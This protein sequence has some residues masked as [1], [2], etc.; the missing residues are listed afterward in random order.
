MTPPAQPS[1]RRSSAS[2]A[3]VPCQLDNEIWLDVEYLGDASSPQASFVND[4]T[5]DL[6]ATAANQSFQLGDMGRLD[7]QVQA[8]GEFHAAAKGLDLC[9]GQVREGIQHVLYRSACH[10]DLAS[11]GDYQ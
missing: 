6:L 11:R 7:H 9:A 4:G 3:A 5:A 1:R 10:A 2:G 8:R